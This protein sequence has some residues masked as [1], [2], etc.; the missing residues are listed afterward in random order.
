MSGE[1]NRG[2]VLTTGGLA[3]LGMRYQSVYDPIEMLCVCTG[4]IYMDI[5]EV[6]LVPDE[7]L[8][9]GRFYNS[10]WSQR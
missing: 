4:N 3:S 5:E 6:H 7:Q 8:W 2:K 10:G 1:N 9:W